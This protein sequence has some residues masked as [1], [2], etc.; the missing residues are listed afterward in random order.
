MQQ[1]VAL[2]RALAVD[3]ESLLMDEPFGALDSMT[4]MRL[5]EEI[6]RIALERAKTKDPYLDLAAF[7]TRFQDPALKR[8][9]DQTMKKAGFN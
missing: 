4:R 7:G 6:G 8:Q 3:P 5:Q 1:R 2:A 9:L